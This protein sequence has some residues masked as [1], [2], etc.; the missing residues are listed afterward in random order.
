MDANKVKVWLFPLSLIRHPKQWYH[1]LPLLT[2]T[3]WATLAVEFIAKYFPLGR[4]Q[5]LKNKILGFT[6]R[7]DEN[8]GEALDRFC[9][10][11]DDFQHHG[12]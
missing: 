5:T 7:A 9:E 3:T 6:Q 11:K 12:L 10:Y 4:T 2:K 8:V 1:A